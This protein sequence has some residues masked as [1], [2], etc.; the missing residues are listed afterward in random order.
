MKALRLD[1][2]GGPQSLRVAEIERPVVREGEALVRVRAAALNR[3][4]L[5][6]TQGLYPKIR[7]PITL[8]SDGAG[9][10]AELGAVV[11]DLN[12]GDE[13]VIDPMLGWGDDPR[14]WDA[15]KSTILGM[16][17]DGTFAHYVAVPIDNLFRKPAALSLEQAAAI[18]LAGLTAYRAVFTR[19]ALQPGETVL[20][21]GV[22]GGVA[23]IRAALCK[24]RRRPHD[25]N[26]RKR[27]KARSRTRDRAPISQ[28]ITRPIPTGRSCFARLVRSISSS[29]RRAARRFVKRSTPYAPEDASSSMAA[30]VARRRSSSF[31]YFGSTSRSWG[32][33]WAVRTI[34]Q[35]C[36][37]S[38]KQCGR[39]SIESLRSTRASPH[40]SV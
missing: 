21:T 31:R 32:R 26:V 5:Y 25:R 15:A 12:V 29:I 11:A 9:E 27:R 30:R 14:L 20:I 6:I 37:A 2:I 7:L 10:I 22:G 13:V 3:R 8:G 40:S 35:R 4:D 24:V 34:L 38:L 19:G 23:D 36:S 18:P 16:P 1:E 39:S 28:S 17:R 33:R